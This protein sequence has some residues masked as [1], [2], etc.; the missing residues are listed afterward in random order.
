METELIVKVDDCNGCGECVKACPCYLFTIDE[1]QKCVVVEENLEHC[2]NCGHCVAS[3][4]NGA[5]ECNGMKSADCTD[6]VNDPADKELLHEFL[7]TRRSIRKYTDKA[8]DRQVIEELLSVAAYA[9][10]GKNTQTV[11]WLVV[12]SK[13]K[14]NELAGEVINWMRYMLEQQEPLAEQFYFAD[15]VDGWEQ[16][17]DGVLR[18]APC[19]VIS[20]STKDD[21]FGPGSAPLCIEYLELAAHAKAMGTCWAGFFDIAC[22]YWPPLQAKLNLPENCVGLGSLMLGYSDENY[23]KI[24]PRNAPDITWY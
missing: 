5:I 8:V 2:L 22:K 1:H 20:Y 23:V 9:P 16:G 19:L 17:V 15:I 21:I 7:K 11:K 4:A 14:V 3:C 24:P 13:D 10:T 18:S 12:S 6:I